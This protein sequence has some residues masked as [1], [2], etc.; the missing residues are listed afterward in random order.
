MIAIAARGEIENGVVREGR[1]A[2]SVRFNAWR[3]HTPLNPYWLELRHLRAAVGSLATEARGRLLDVGVGERPWGAL[4]EQRVTRY[5]GLEY[6]PVADHLSP[7]VWRALERLRGIVDVFGDGARLPFRDGTFDTLLAVEVLEHVPDPSL[8]VA[9]FARV[10]EPGG[11]LLLTVPFTAARHQLPFDYARFTAEGVALLLERHGF[12]I[13]R[14]SQRGNSASVVGTTLA[15]FLLR[16]FAASSVLKDGSVTVSRWRG[17]LVMP[18]IA[19]V[20]MAFALAGRMTRD[21]ALCLGHTVVAR[22][23]AVARIRLA[24]EHDRRARSADHQH[25][26][27]PADRLVVQVDRDHGVRAETSRLL[28]QLLERDLLGAPQ[29]A[30]VRRGAAADDV[31]D[32][33]EQVLEDVRAEDRLA[34]DDAEVADGGAAF[35]GGGGGEDH[36]R[37]YGRNRRPFDASSG[38]GRGIRA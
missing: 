36:G 28:G 1:R 38:E 5:V 17:L 32:A 9:E 27:V 23:P 31:A 20:Q 13:E 22:K 25:R 37:R 29:L 12:Q 10:L 8:C 15:H 14:L 7:G 19:L 21:D 18:L 6:P 35:D 11:R 2:L 4:F 30:L 26:A 33:G 3:K 24:P 34:A 16:T